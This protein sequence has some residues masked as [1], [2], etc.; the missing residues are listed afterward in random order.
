MKRFDYLHERSNSILMM[1]FDGGNGEIM[2]F[3]NTY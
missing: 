2:L 1:L 3:M